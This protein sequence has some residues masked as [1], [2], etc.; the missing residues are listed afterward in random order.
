[1][2]EHGVAL[3]VQRSLIELLEVRAL[4]LKKAVGAASGR[5]GQ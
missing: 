2:Q 3:R 5:R 1:M 4:K